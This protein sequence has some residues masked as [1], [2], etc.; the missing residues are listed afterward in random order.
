MFSVK[1]YL[2][3]ALEMEVASHPKSERVGFHQF[4][5]IHSWVPLCRVMVTLGDSPRAT[6]QAGARAI[7]ARRYRSFLHVFV[8]LEASFWWLAY[9]NGGAVLRLLRHTL[10]TVSPACR[11]AVIEPG[12]PTGSGQVSAYF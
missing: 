6:G 10:A 2:L 3:V 9:Q 12:L 1:V 4:L 5:Y 11:S 8:F 7:P